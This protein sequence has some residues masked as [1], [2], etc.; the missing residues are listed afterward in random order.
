GELA[1][2]AA[3]GSPLPEGMSHELQATEYFDVTGIAFAYA[4]HVAV[5]EVDPETG[6]VTPVRYCVVHDSG[7]L[8]NPLIV[9]GQVPGGVVQG[10]GGTLMEELMYDDDG[11]PLNPNFVDYLMPAVG[12]VPPIEV[13]HMETPTP[14]N[15]MGMK[16][17]GEGGAVGSPAALV[18]AVEDAV[19]HLGV[20]V[21][22]SPVTP[23]SLFDLLAA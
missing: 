23:N 14:L 21:L 13:G 9:D 5:V 10:L 20:R 1:A 4:T 3:P 16:G 15:P 6:V 2:A 12:N 17:A 8:I 11:Q 7:T 19:A 18:N 22:S